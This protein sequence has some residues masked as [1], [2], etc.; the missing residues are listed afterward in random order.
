MTAHAMCNMQDLIRLEFYC[1]TF[2]AIAIPMQVL[3]LCSNCAHFHD[4]ETPQNHYVQLVCLSC[5]CH[6]SHADHCFIPLQWVSWLCHILTW[7]FVHV[8]CYYYSS[9]ML[10]CFWLQLFPYYAQH[11]GF[12]PRSNTLF[13]SQYMC[14]PAYGYHAQV[15]KCFQGSG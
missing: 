14:C 8:P 10:K 12:K 5:L 2:L 3:L 9:I 11:N 15:S 7:Q 6:C 4:W 13:T 1:K